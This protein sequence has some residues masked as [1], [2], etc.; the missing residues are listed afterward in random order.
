M[1]IALILV[2]SL[3][4]TPDLRD[5]NARNALDVMRTPVAAIM[6]TACFVQ[7]QA[8]LAQMQIGRDLRA[9]EAPRVICQRR[10][11]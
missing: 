4:I 2:C 1:L 11:D 8:F 3:H 7:G 9:D 5:C 10:A 6:P